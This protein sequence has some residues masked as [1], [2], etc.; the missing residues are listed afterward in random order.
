MAVEGSQRQKGVVMAKLQLRATKGK[1]V[2]VERHY[3]S[4]P[5]RHHMKEETIE[6]KTKIN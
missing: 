3:H 5:E 6:E 2:Y 4:R 1:Q